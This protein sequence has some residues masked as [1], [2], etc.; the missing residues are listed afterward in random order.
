MVNKNC[1]VLCTPNSIARGK[2]SIAEKENDFF[3]KIMYC[4]Q[5]DNREYIITKRRYD[6]LSVEEHD[7][8]NALC[9]LE[10]LQCRITRRDINEIFK[11]RNDRTNEAIELLIDKLKSCEISFNTV[12]RDGVDAELKAPLISHRYIE[13]ETGDYLIVVPAKLYK[14]L[15][16]LGLGYSQNVLQILYSLKGNYAKRL[17]LILR[18]WTGKKRQIEIK[19]SEL[20]DMLQVNDKND[21]FNRF[22][23]NVLK[24]AIKEINALGIME[25]KIA[26][27]IRKGR[28]VDS[29][30]FDVV[31]K[32]PRKYIKL[33]S[34]STI[35]VE[36]IL[37]L[38]YIKLES[39]SIRERLEAKYRDMI[40]ESPFVRKIFCDAYDKTL[41]RDNRFNMIQD[42][43]G[44]TNFK[45]FIAII[46]GEFLTHD[47]EAEN[48]FKKSFESELY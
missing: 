21:T 42:K 1:E 30:I 26:D 22:E 39:E 14:Y 3:Y 2:Y 29:V 34:E 17:Y 11:N 33:A 8:W 23:T 13:K 46:D 32:E 41:A 44:Q 31:D 4:V 24:R 28:S 19:V 45:L 35:E 10:T 27:K 16:D 36:P 20:R 25:I 18:S 40:F 43:K 9:K 7:K 47:L 48:Q 12:T 37:W 38:D 6:D 5:R 15:F